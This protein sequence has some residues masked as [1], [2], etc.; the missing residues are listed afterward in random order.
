MGYTSK[1]IKPLFYLLHSVHLKLFSITVMA[2]TLTDSVTDLN[3]SE[4]AKSRILAD[5]QPAPIS[6]IHTTTS[7]RINLFPQSCCIS[8]SHLF[9]RS[10]VAAVIKPRDTIGGP[11]I[12]DAPLLPILHA[13][14]VRYARVKIT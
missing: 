7:R 13:T 10:C 1:I 5:Q 8:R 6:P 3:V 2:S 12:C 9:V 4:I 11:D 14:W